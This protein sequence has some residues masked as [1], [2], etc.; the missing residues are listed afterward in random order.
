MS[1]E[2]NHLL[3]NDGVCYPKD[4]NL[5]FEWLWDKAAEEGLTKAKVQAAINKIGKWISECEKN[6]PREGVFEG[7]IE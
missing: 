5:F 2:L 6:A 7:L 4:I 3:D 1:P